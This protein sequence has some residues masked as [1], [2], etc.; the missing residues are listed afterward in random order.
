MPADEIPDWLSNYTPYKEWLQS[1]QINYS[2]KEKKIQ[3]L[4]LAINHWYKKFENKVL[5]LDEDEQS[6][7]IA[8][9]TNCHI[10][11]WIQRAKQDPQFD[12]SWV[13]ILDKKH[14][15]MHNMAEN[16]LN[17]YQLGN[18]D[19]AINEL[20]KLKKTFMQITSILDEAIHSDFHST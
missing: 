15:S 10:G 3:L 11:S 7:P 4:Q 14:I 13:N 5:E 20:K 1:D 12:L 9:H 2:V 19:D 8:D 17:E 16:I 6:W 18:K